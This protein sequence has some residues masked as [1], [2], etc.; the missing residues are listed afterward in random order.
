ML[1]TMWG[2]CSPTKE[3]IRF[4]FHLLLFFNFFRFVWQ[5]PIVSKWRQAMDSTFS[6]LLS[7]FLP[8]NP[9]SPQTPSSR[10]SVPNG[11]GRFDRANFIL[12]GVEVA[13]A[14]VVLVMASTQVYIQTLFFSKKKKRQDE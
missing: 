7:A 5:P 14:E 8:L 3:R 1:L 2:L 4:S 11:S 13:A 6:L 12:A 9:T 10:K